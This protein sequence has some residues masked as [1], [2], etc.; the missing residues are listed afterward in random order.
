M[1]HFFVIFFH[2]FHPYFWFRSLWSK[3]HYTNKKT[4]SSALL[5]RCRCCWYWYCSFSGVSSP[6]VAVSHTNIHNHSRINYFGTLILLYIYNTHSL[7][8]LNQHLNLTLNSSFSSFTCKHL[9]NKNTTSSL[10]L[11]TL[12]SPTLADGH[13]WCSLHSLRYVYQVSHSYLI[14][15]K[16]EKKAKRFAI[17][18]MLT[19][20]LSISYSFCVCWFN[21]KFIYS[22]LF[23]LTHKTFLM[24]ISW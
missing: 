11:I 24:F 12:N 5:W 22:S 10:I 14:W 17:S 16:N 6:P 1:F 4:P 9:E 2:V 19:F 20:F 18:F 3:N 21:F 15:N 7:A 8:H 23:L 13:A